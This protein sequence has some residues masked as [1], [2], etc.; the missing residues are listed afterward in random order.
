M[1]WLIKLVY[2]II[3]LSIAGDF[4]SLGR[5][6]LYSTSDSTGVQSTLLFPGADAI[7][8]AI[9]KGA[10]KAL[11]KSAKKAAK[12]KAK[13]QAKTAG[14]AKNKAKKA[15]GKGLCVTR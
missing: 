1:A 11:S 15:N 14:R 12:R 7:W 3:V 9:A 5:H 8:G 10:A 6:F 4:L 2:L 13:N